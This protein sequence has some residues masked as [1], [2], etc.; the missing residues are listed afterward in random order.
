MAAGSDTEGLIQIPPAGCPDQGGLPGP[1][2]NQNFRNQANLAITAIFTD[3]KTFFDNDMRAYVPTFFG[4]HA[5]PL[6]PND[7]EYDHVAM[8]E[9]DFVMRQLEYIFALSESS[10]E[11]IQEL[12]SGL[13]LR[14]MKPGAMVRQEGTVKA[15]VAQAG[16][17]FRQR[18]IPREKE[19]DQRRKGYQNAA[20]KYGIDDDADYLFHLGDDDA[21][22]DKNKLN[23]LGIPSLAEFVMSPGDPVIL[24]NP[25][26]KPA[27]NPER[28][29]IALQASAEEEGAESPSI[30][31][32]E[33]YDMTKKS[34][35]DEFSRVLMRPMDS[36]KN[37]VSILPSVRKILLDQRNFRA[38]TSNSPYYHLDIEYMLS[39]LSQAVGGTRDKYGIVGSRDTGVSLMAT[40]FGV[41]SGA[42]GRYINDS[43]YR[44]SGN[45][46]SHYWNLLLSL[47]H[48]AK[49]TSQVSPTF[50]DS[51][52]IM[53]KAIQEGP[54]SIRGRDLMHQVLTDIM[55]LPQSDFDEV[56]IRDLNG[57]TEDI[58]S[59]VN[60]SE[61][62]LLTPSEYAYQG[63]Q[64]FPNLPDHD[65]DPSTPG[66][67]YELT[68]EQFVQKELSEFA[69]SCFLKFV[70]VL[71]S[72]Q[73]SIAN[74]I[75]TPGTANDGFDTW[76]DSI[77]G[78]DYD[79]TKDSK[80]YI[81]NDIARDRASYPYSEEYIKIRMPES[82]K[83]LFLEI[84]GI[85][86][87]QMV[88][89]VKKHFKISIGGMIEKA[90]HHIEKSQIHMAELPYTGPK[91][92]IK[93]CYLV[94]RW[95]SSPYYNIAGNDNPL[96]MIRHEVF[97]EE[98]KEEYRN[99][100]ADS[101]DLSGKNNA[102]KLLLRP[103]AY[104]DILFKKAEQ[105]YQP[106]DIIDEVF[107]SNN[108]NF[109]NNHYRPES[110][111][112]SAAW[113]FLTDRLPT[114][115][116]D[117][118]YAKTVDR[119]MDK[120]AYEIANSKYFET[121]E[122]SYL[123]N[124]ITNVKKY[125][126]FLK[127]RAILNTEYLGELLRKGLNKATDYGDLIHHTVGY[128]PEDGQFI[129]PESYQSEEPGS[130]SGRSFLNSE[131]EF[132]EYDPIE[133]SDY[134]YR[135]AIRGGKFKTYDFARCM[136]Q[137]K[138]VIDFE[139]VKEAALKSF[140]NSL[141]KE[142]YSPLK[143]D[144]TKQGPLE[145]ELQGQ[146]VILYMKTYVYEFLLNGILMFGNMSAGG[147][148]DSE[149]V[150]S[151]IVDSVFST[152]S[153]DFD[154]DRGFQVSFINKL[155]NLLNEDDERLAL[156]KMVT[157]LTSEAINEM[158]KIADEIFQPDFSSFK[159]QLFNELAS[160]FLDGGKHFEEPQYRRRKTRGRFVQGD[161]YVDFDAF[162]DTV[163][164]H[165]G[166]SAFR[167]IVL[168]VTYKNHPS[169]DLYNLEAT[170]IT[171]EANQAGLAGVGE[172]NNRGAEDLEINDAISTQINQNESIRRATR[173]QF[174]RRRALDLPIAG[175]GDLSEILNMQD[176]N[177]NPRYKYNTAA[178]LARGGFYLEKY[179]ELDQAGLQSL[180]DDYLVG[181]GG[182]ESYNVFLNV[183]EL[184]E[185]NGL[186]APFMS[187]T[188]TDDA[189]GE[190]FSTLAELSSGQGTNR[191]LTKTAAAIG[192]NDGL[193]HPVETFFKMKYWSPSDVTKLWKYIIRVDPDNSL[194]A[195]EKCSEILS[196]A[197]IGIR[198]M[199]IMPELYDKKTSKKNFIGDSETLDI[200][201]KA[202]PTD[203]ANVNDLSFVNARQDIDNL[204]MQS[205]FLYPYQYSGR[206][207][208][209]S[210]P[211]TAETL[212]ED[213]L[214]SNIY[215]N[216]PTTLKSDIA[217][218]VQSI[219]AYATSYADLGE[220]SQ[221]ELAPQTLDNKLARRN[222]F[223]RTSFKH[224]GI[225]RI[226]KCG[227][228]IWSPSGKAERYPLRIKDFNAFEYV[229]DKITKYNDELSKFRSAYR[230]YY[231]SKIENPIATVQSWY[232]SL[233]DW[234]GNAFGANPITPTT[235]NLRER[236]LES[237]LFVTAQN[238]GT[239]NDL[240]A[241][242]SL[243]KATYLGGENGV[244]INQGINVNNPDPELLRQIKLFRGIN[245]N[246]SE[247]SELLNEEN[248]DAGGR[249]LH[250]Y[251]DSLALNRKKIKFVVPITE[252]NGGNIDLNPD[253]ENCPILGND[254]NID[255]TSLEKLAEKYNDRLL[256][257]L[258]GLGK[259][260]K[261]VN[262]TVV[263]KLEHYQSANENIKYF[264]DFVFPLDRY[265]DLFFIHN[266]TLIKQ[267]I[268]IQDNGYLEPTRG[269]IRRQYRIL[270]NV[271]GQNKASQNFNMT[272]QEFAEVLK[273]A[274]DGKGPH[275]NEGPDMLKDIGAALIRI[276]IMT[277]I[278][279]V[280]GISIMLDPAYAQM[281]T[282]M[283]TDPCKLRKGLLWGSVGVGGV[284]PGRV[285]D[286]ARVNGGAGPDCN[287]R[288]HPIPWA[289]IPDILL[290]VADLVK[291]FTMFLG[292]PPFVYP[293]LIIKGAS[294]LAN[295]LLHIKGAITF[296][297]ERSYGSILG[298]AG[299]IA[300]SLPE[301]P[302]EAHKR[303]HKE[304]GCAE[305]SDP[306]EPSIELPETMDICE[307]VQ[308][309]LEQ[310]QEELQSQAQSG[311]QII[312]E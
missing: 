172:L 171:R 228:M 191:A 113:G 128:R 274:E 243:G 41:E 306:C 114:F 214:T 119:L 307:L 264:F 50:P 37:E 92:N 161:L 267:A 225:N 40:V 193:T 81:K 294:T 123:G 59:R 52:D 221:G 203:T 153:R 154:E 10:D 49:A 53:R 202:V 179:F 30:I 99:K 223:R 260:K 23:S 94:S 288:F 138:P 284:Y 136:I 198:L 11:E 239:I 265:Q 205:E 200:R 21:G 248:L 104:G 4:P 69:R 118:V 89:N 132:I 238:F 25:A 145:I 139:Q 251:L 54:S 164:E 226:H 106:S 34:D 295:T 120:V 208:T 142:E 33:V 28:Q 39:S 217:Q 244:R 302:G 311:G 167:K 47:W 299:A 234:F 201:I 282:L 159:E 195:R 51:G 48:Q 67:R 3:I 12:A 20:E 163:Q 218:F 219:E 29:S 75:V 76:W 87:K 61:F 280:R 291:G 38:E 249:L 9:Y 107:S 170:S 57:I 14:I 273:N 241:L 121:D 141:C 277:P 130:H 235:E 111:E 220:V 16:D 105:L 152:I 266:E 62:E 157:S 101:I 108:N 173:A 281:K 224:S 18:V 22:P 24:P 270:E 190:A 209:L 242:V 210:Q 27:D 100:R 149:F 156:K 233:P 199:Q 250:K 55:G 134:Q 98:I 230:A 131:G 103:G 135:D 212:N 36:M 97:T 272:Q 155:K 66:Q 229:S 185:N 90:Q 197:T 256:K 258:L 2:D 196:S 158:T 150:K 297:G 259:E 65:N 309:D 279:I 82:W 63:L 166:G 184:M 174:A 215:G 296:S 73:K 56:S 8:A 160:D 168:P 278:S 247:I 268:S 45:V 85:V 60:S 236:F 283:E 271:P 312:E 84:S 78:Q 68:R 287:N 1:Y 102:D 292:F 261:T 129:D 182:F 122:M 188:D 252:F 13:W 124:R 240:Q 143:R 86:E 110:I 79:Y 88:M 204:F 180:L 300:L 80:A 222:I 176:A 213:A 117:S 71:E 254:G 147:L 115:Q 35:Q 303:R 269:A 257:G 181:V 146:L 137:N 216:F 253:Q 126:Y 262:N 95:G 290:S 42:L 46:V 237:P 43:R 19:E 186:Q 175:F 7:P 275:G 177:G 15:Y 194:G 298:P 192:F 31:K 305:R 32:Y 26:I 144:F 77:Q 178:T 207:A 44:N 5:R 74:G 310:K 116:Q 187:A 227:A 246:L 148:F 286:G 58:L 276:A 263:R 231:S 6:N 17:I 285:E 125:V 96:Y 109:I 151:Y 127:N 183:G 165:G 64:Q 293:P 301:V 93:D 70:S 308:D 162:E 169:R 232:A 91:E 304:S 140:F 83:V 189:I 255:S 206:A 211:N 289:P 112:K 245:K 72:L 133:V